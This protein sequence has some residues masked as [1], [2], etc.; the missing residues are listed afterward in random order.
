MDP[1]SDDPRDR[2]AAKPPDEHSVVPPDPERAEYRSPY[3]PVDP[4]EVPQVEP[5]E[6]EPFQFS[7]AELLL[8]TALVSVLL[9]ILG[10]F[11]QQYAA[12]LAGLGALVSMLALAILKPTR[13]IMYVGWWFVLGIYLLSCVRAIVG[14]M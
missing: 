11:P 4:N 9:G 3:G 2:S 1:M 10:C 12:G 6:K 5:T 7:L 13:A 14:G 8:L